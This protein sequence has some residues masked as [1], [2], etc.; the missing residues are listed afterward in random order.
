[1]RKGGLSITIKG[2]DILNHYVRRLT[3][4]EAVGE[5]DGMTVTFQMPQKK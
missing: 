4:T 1:M 5:L 3:Y 2:K